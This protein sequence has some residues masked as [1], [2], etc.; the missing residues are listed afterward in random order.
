MGWG[1]T[2][3]D[4]TAQE[5]SFVELPCHFYVGGAWWGRLLVAGRARELSIRKKLQC[6]FLD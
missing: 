3:T 5:P 4:S 2:T 6:R 1:L